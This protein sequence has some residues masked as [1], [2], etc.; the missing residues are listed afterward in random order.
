MVTLPAF[1]EIRR[2]RHNCRAR[3]EEFLDVAKYEFKKPDLLTD[4]EIADV[5]FIANRLSTWAN[6]VH[7]FASHLADRKSVV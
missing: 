3:A 4:E 1:S 7:S 6:D 5:L 2:V